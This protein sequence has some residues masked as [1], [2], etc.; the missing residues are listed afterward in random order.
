M[1]YTLILN[2]IS[3]NQI[4]I[5]EYVKEINYNVVALSFVVAAMVVYF[6]G[7]KIVGCK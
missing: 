3:N 5:L 6:V 7:R 2:E 4:L 1:D